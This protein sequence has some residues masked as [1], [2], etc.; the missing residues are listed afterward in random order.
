[1]FDLFVKGNGLC[2]RFDAQVFGQQAA[3]SFK[4]SQSLTAPTVQSQQAHEQAVGFF[5]PVI[6]RHYAPGVGDAVGGGLL[7]VGVVG[8]TVQ[9]LYHQQA[10]AFPFQ[11]RPFVKGR[12]VGHVKTF[13]KIAAIKSNGRFPGG[14][15]GGE[16]TAVS[17]LFTSRVIRSVLRL[18]VWWVRVRNGRSAG[19]SRFNVTRKLAR[20]AASGVSP[21][22]SPANASREQVWPVTAR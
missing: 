1:M 17:K 18:M 16:G 15:I 21:H 14:G 6:Q 10:Q 20:A 9:Q 7:L 4:L 2:G 5:A 11:Q 13:Q 3:A 19:G 12:G 8:Q 22:S